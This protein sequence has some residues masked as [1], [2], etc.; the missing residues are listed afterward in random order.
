MNSTTKQSTAIPSVELEAAKT[1]QISWFSRQAI[2]FEAGRFAWMT[3][4][5][6]LQSCL[7]SIACMY[8]LQTGG[9]TVMLASGTA[10][11]MASNA[12]MIAQSPGKACLA[13]FY[14]SL[15]VNISLIAI[16]AFA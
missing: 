15:L 16:N 14:I 12:A 5:M 13:F 11:T 1:G 6:T 3:I 2:Q 9:D 7:G 10:V 4:L 8:V